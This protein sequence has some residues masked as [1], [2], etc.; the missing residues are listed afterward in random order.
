MV[1]DVQKDFTKNTIFDIYLTNEKYEIS[2]Y[3][4][5]LALLL[6]S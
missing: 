4:K 5:H 6:R 2:K 3:K 1:G